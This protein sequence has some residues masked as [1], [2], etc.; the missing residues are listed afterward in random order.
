MGDVLMPRFDYQCDR[1]ACDHLDPNV[2][3][4]VSDVSMLR[5]CPICGSDMRKLPSAPNF[6][7]R[8][9][10]AKSGYSRKDS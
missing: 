7:I 6:V 2:Y 8:G 3:V 9:Y 1:P 5:A 10:N 4:P